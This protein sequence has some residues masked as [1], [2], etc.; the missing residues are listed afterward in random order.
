MLVPDQAEEIQGYPH[1]YICIYIYIYMCVCEC[2]C[3]RERER[4]RERERVYVCSWLAG[5][6]L[7]HINTY[8]LFNAKFIFIKINS[9]ISN[10]SL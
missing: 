7:W 4:E 9:S 3:V 2:V 8:R 10:N 1:I 5:W 6:V